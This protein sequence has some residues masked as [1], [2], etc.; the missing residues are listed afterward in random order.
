MRVAIRRER[1]NVARP[2]RRDRSTGPGAAPALGPPCAPTSPP[3]L[4]LVVPALLPARAHASS[5]YLGPD[6]LSSPTPK[7]GCPIVIS[8]NA[9]FG[10]ADPVVRAIRNTDN[11]DV[12]GTIAHERRDIA[13]PYYQ[14]D[15]DGLV[16]DENDTVEPYDIFTIE[17]SDKAQAGDMIYADGLALTTLQPAGD[18]IP[19][20]SRCRSAT[21][22]PTSAT[23]THRRATTP[24]ASAA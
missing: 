1:A 22:W 18:A 17:L 20:S 12:T 15:C 13:T 16:V 24:P 14:L 3:C 7:L 4:A 2:T 6:L 19:S 23:T 8:R 5:C 10:T 11:L 21:S 9:Y